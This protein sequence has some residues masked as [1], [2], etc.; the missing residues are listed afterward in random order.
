MGK[1]IAFTAVG[2]LALVASCNQIIG[3]KDVS[4][5]TDD[6]G[7]DAD[8]SDAAI[9]AQPDAMVDAM[10]DAPPPKV[11]TFVTDQGFR[12]SFGSPNGARAT[13]DIKCQ[14]KYNLTFSSTGATPRTCSIANVHAVIQVDDTVDSIARMDITFP[15][16]QGVPIQR[17]TD[18]SITAPDWDT[19]VNPNAALTAPV[20]TS[21]T[22]VKFW[23]GRGVASNLSCTGWTNGTAS[24]VGN[25][26]DATKVSTWFSQSNTTCDDFSV[27]LLCVCW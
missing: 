24:V 20:S 25:A 11:W 1:H 26:G 15:I 10:I 5:V 23:S 18:E 19:F 3:F 16:P 7:T 21:G 14:D 4:L 8:A 2:L 6:G 27:K 9:D 22:A 13:A 17:A 12:G